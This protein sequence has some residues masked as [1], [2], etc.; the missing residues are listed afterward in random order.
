MAYHIEY[1]PITKSHFRTLTAMSKRQTQAIQV[2]DIQVTPVS[3]D[4]LDEES[5]VLSNNPQFLAIIQQARSEKQKGG[6]YSEEMIRWVEMELS[7]DSR[8]G[9]CLLVLGE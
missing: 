9:E 6:F 1:L 2:E 3:E 4:G 8:S 5:K 7:Q